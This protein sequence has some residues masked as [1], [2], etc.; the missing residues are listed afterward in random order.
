MGT[1]RAALIQASKRGPSKCIS[2]LS[3]FRLKEIIAED[4][5]SPKD[6]FIN[7]LKW[8]P[9]H[10]KKACTIVM[11]CR[12]LNTTVSLCMWVTYLYHRVSCVRK[13]KTIKSCQLTSSLAF[14]HYQGGSLCVPHWYANRSPFARESWRRLSFVGQLRAAIKRRA[15]LVQMPWLWRE[16]DA[17]HPLLRLSLRTWGISSS[18]H[19]SLQYVWVC[20]C[21]SGFIQKQQTGSL[22]F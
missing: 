13:M 15:S 1:V 8:H 22:I 10:N 12:F 7:S 2:A 9:S 18:G 20:G 4:Q 6:I 16:Q 11:P 21:A 5:K 19:G 17:L 14:C 3:T